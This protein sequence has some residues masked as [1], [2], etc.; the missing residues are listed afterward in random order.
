MRV[1]VRSLQGNV[2]GDLELHQSSVYVVAPLILRF[3]SCLAAAHSS[4]MPGQSAHQHS[5]LR[6]SGK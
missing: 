5:R 3:R 1:E 2:F 4:W 6:A